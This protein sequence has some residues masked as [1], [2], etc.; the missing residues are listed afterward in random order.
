VFGSGEPVQRAAVSRRRVYRCA[1]ALWL[2]LRAV[3]KPVTDRPS[4]E[5]KRCQDGKKVLWCLDFDLRSK[6]DTLPIWQLL[7]CVV[8][9][10]GTVAAGLFEW[11][12]FARFAK[13][14]I[15][16]TTSA[17]RRSQLILSS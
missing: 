17:S 12:N 8:V 16:S 14:S 9:K 11:P 13:Y 4:A 2:T 5:P 10:L 3:V 7:V 15:A 1:A 6:Q